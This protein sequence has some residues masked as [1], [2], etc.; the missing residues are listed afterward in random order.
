[1]IVDFHPLVGMF[2]ETGKVILPYAAGG[3]P[4]RWDKGV[5]DY[6]AERGG[7]SLT[8]SGWEAG[9]QG[10]AN[11]EPCWEF[12]WSLGEIVQAVIDAGLNLEHLSEWTYANAWQPF[13]NM[14]DLGH[15]R[16]AASEPLA[17]MPLMFGL[18][19]ARRGS[20]G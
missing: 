12:A 13:A 9:E 20:L 15:G 4:F 7:A 19:A 3:V 1:V 2:D 18:G 14:K 6:V 10:F 17:G 8:P 16:F 5:N 11:P